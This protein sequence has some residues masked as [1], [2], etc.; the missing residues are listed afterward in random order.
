MT[1]PARR[2]VAIVG[3]SGCGKSTMLGLLLRLHDPSTGTVTFDGTDLRR[4]TPASLRSQVGVM[5]Q[6]SYLFDL[7]VRENIR[8]GRP[9][10]TDQEVE[11]AAR[12]AGIHET[13]RRLPQGYD[14]PVGERG[15]RLSGER[16]PLGQRDP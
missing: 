15:A 13:L 11:T 3:P 1:I 12:D 2:F 7:S 4:A 14:T 6:E 9:S 5:H 10:A 16:D 8:L